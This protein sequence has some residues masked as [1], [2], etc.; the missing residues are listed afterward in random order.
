ML[1]KEDKLKEEEEDMLSERNGLRR[2]CW[3][4]RRAGQV[5]GLSD[6]RCIG[7][8]ACRDNRLSNR[9]RRPTTRSQQQT[10]R[11]TTRKSCTG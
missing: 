11:E 5:A 2:P 4:A 7:R 10:A 9:S 3:D 1:D 8:G 6:V